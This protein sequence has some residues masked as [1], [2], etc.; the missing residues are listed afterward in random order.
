M[1]PN[2]TIKEFLKKRPLSWSA[3]SSFEWNPEE[4]YERYILA[5][6]EP[7]TPELE[8]GK[9]V[10]EKLAD[11]PDF[12]PH[13]PR[14]RHFE[15]E[16]RAELAGIPLIGYVDSYEPIL[17]K[18]GP[19]LNEYKTGKKPWDKKRV[20][21]HGQLTMYALMLYLQNKIVPNLLQMHLVWLP[22]KQNGDFSIDFIDE[23]DAR[24]FE[25]RRTLTQC[26]TFGNHIKKTVQA[27]ELF[28]LSRI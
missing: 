18:K 3:I 10:G 20:D 13:V 6:R 11:D 21:E 12:L 4:W 16:L 26:L 24:V 14:Y 23:K 25:T 9:L 7:P 15:Y 17:S 2:F 8:F 27:M 1:T 22:T 28:A 19:A 5:K